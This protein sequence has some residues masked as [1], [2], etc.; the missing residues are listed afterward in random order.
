MVA[1]WK[2][3]RALAKVTREPEGGDRRS[4]TKQLSGFWTW[5]KKTL[6]LEP[7]TVVDVIGADPEWKFETWSEAG[8]DRSAESH[9]RTFGSFAMKGIV[10]SARQF[11]ASSA[12]YPRL[13]RSL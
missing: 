5:T 9:Y 8:M 2:L 13:P 1:R 10:A 11:S 4:T 12:C 7:P 6:G 3:G